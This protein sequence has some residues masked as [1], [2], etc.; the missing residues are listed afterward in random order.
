MQNTVS[1]S[2]WLDF[3]LI[4]IC[5]REPGCNEKYTGSIDIE[6]LKYLQRVLD[7]PRDFIKKSYDMKTQLF[8]KDVWEGFLSKN[9][10]DHSL[11]TTRS[12]NLLDICTV[13]CM[14]HITF[15]D[16]ES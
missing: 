11:N 15:L 1:Y 3:V 4:N 16:H 10:G 12:K 7:Y 14:T 5:E 8:A 6:I 9:I 2:L 13:V